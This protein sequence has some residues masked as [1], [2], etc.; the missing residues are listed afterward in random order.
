MDFSYTEEERMMLQMTRDFAEKTV[1]P[2]AEETDRHHLSVILLPLRSFP[3]IVLL[4]G[5]L[6]PSIILWLVNR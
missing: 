3:V 2:L 1:K 6:F 4:P 5:L